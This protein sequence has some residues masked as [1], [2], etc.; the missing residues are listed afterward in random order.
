M[1]RPFRRAWIGNLRSFLMTDPGMEVVAMLRRKLDDIPAVFKQAFGHANPVAEI[2]GQFEIGKFFENRPGGPWISEI[3]QA[4][5][6]MADRHAKTALHFQHRTVEI[7][8]FGWT[9]RVGTAVGI[10][11]QRI[12][13]HAFI[14]LFLHR[15]QMFAHGATGREIAAEDLR[16]PAPS[17][18]F[19]E[20]EEG[21]AIRRQLEAALHG[22]VAD[23]AP[24]GQIVIQAVRVINAPEVADESEFH[25]ICFV[26]TGDLLEF[27]ERD[28]AVKHAEFAEHF[29]AS[30]D[31]R[32]RSAKV[33]L[34]PAPGGQSCPGGGV[35]MRMLKRSARSVSLLLA[36]E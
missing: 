25:V 34:E 19:E 30:L 17:A 26:L 8:R 4:M 29:R 33:E 32:G 21:F 3:P 22:R 10:E 12:I 11:E 20:A 6:L 5:R 15:I 28:V 35:A 13:S 23:I 16:N 36:S 31:H 27:V 7:L 2:A 14:D 1:P 18:G 24:A 9:P